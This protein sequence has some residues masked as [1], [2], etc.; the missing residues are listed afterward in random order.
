MLES[1][2]A[3]TVLNFATELR[4]QARTQTPLLQTS[5]SFRQMRLVLVVLGLVARSHCQPPSTPPSPPPPSPPPTPPPPSPPPSPPAAPP[6]PS[7]PRSAATVTVTLVAAGS[8][9]DYNETTTTNLRNKFAQAAEVRRPY[10]PSPSLPPLPRHPY[11]ELLYPLHLSYPLPP[12]PLS[13]PSG[14]PVLRRC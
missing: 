9:S 8:V 14:P 7:P 10:L 13:P 1:P 3:S 2:I 11:L 6:P 5:R 4:K 12:P